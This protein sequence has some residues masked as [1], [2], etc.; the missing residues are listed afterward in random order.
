VRRFL[1]KP[2]LAEAQAQTETYLINAGTYV[3]DPAIFDQ[4]PAET[5]WSFER[6]LFP[7]LLEAGAPVFSYHNRGC[8]LDCGS[9]AAY[10]QA[11]RDLLAG[12]LPRPEDWR[13]WPSP[14]DP[15]VFHEG[16]M[17]MPPDLEVASGPVFLGRGV[18]LGT[19]VKLGPYAVIGPGARLADGARVEGAIVGPRVQVCRQ[20]EILGGV[21]GADSWIGPNARV[22][23][24]HLLA[25]RSVI[26]RGSCLM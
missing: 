13:A 12:R 17:K 4:V 19:G 9:P 24:N 15:R 11:H 16:P 8:W 3:L 14:E 7:S 6:Q 21:I 26:G 2:T 22:L 18:E 20:A 1:E 5:P 23:G 10:V 25:D